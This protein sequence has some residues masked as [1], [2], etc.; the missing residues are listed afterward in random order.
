MSEGVGVCMYVCVYVCMRER[1]SVCEVKKDGE[2]ALTNFIES[3][4]GREKRV[5]VTSCSPLFL[6][7]CGGGPEEGKCATW[8][9]GLVARSSRETR[10][11]LGVG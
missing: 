9:R 10:K 4:L 8:C 2:E 7:Q 6:L 1:D 3:S 11:G 5:L